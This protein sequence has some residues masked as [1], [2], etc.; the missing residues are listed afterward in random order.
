MIIKMKYIKSFRI[1]GM[2][3]HDDAIKLKFD[4]D[5]VSITSIDPEVLL[6]KGENLKP[7][8]WTLLIKEPKKYGQVDLK[9]LSFRMGPI[10]TAA[11]LSLL[12]KIF[13]YRLY[14]LEHRDHLKAL[15]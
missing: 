8:H 7:E 15:I 6:N 2:R 4:F 3:F 12:Y 13:P 1:S 14:W 5:L 10:R 9:E 11:A